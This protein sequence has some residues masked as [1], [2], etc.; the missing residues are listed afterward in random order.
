MGFRSTVAAQLPATH[1]AIQHWES[2]PWRSLV[3][4][5]REQ[6]QLLLMEQAWRT[7]MPSQ[8]ANLSRKKKFTIPFYVNLLDMRPIHEASWKLHLGQGEMAIYILYTCQPSLPATSS[9]NM[10]RR[11]EGLSSLA[12]STILL[13]QMASRETQVP[14]H[15]LLEEVLVEVQHNRYWKEAQADLVFF[16][17]VKSACWCF[18]LPLLLLVVFHGWWSCQIARF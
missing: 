15:Q 16:E 14:F 8:A 3:Q 13:C 2:L 11:G 1:L 10:S 4:P 7:Q 18:L 6:W 17:H 12:F 5:R 9:F